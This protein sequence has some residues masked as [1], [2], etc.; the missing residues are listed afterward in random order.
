MNAYGRLMKVFAEVRNSF[1][2]SW[3]K[4]NK[5][6]V[7]LEAE[8]PSAVVIEIPWTEA[9]ETPLPTEIG[10]NGYCDRET[11]T[12]YINPALVDSGGDGLRFTL[13]REICHAIAGPSH[14]K[15]WQTRF[16]K[17]GHTAKG[18]GQT[19]LADR[20]RKEVRGVVEFEQA[21]EISKTGLDYY[22]EDALKDYPEAEFQDILHHLALRW[23]YA[24]DDDLLERFPQLEI[25]YLVTKSALNTR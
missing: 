25:I 4:I 8:S 9:P 6:T 17:V 20:I 12:I 2:P 18:Q 5:W 7:I 10:Y 19:R 1:F 22:V 15:K 13:A 16:L 21:I 3:D 23:G 24:D 14:R 11:K